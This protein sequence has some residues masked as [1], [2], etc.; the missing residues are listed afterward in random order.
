MKSVN[1]VLIATEEELLAEGWDGIDAR[2]E[3]P[4]IPMLQEGDGVT[5]EFIGGDLAMPDDDSEETRG[6]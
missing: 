3:M 5:F 6:E 2:Y 1:G 4:D